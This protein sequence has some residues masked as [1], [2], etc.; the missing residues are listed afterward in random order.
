LINQNRESITSTST[1]I[2]FLFSQ[3]LSLQFFDS[4]GFFTLRLSGDQSV[5]SQ[6]NLGQKLD[7]NSKDPDEQKLQNVVEEMAIAAGTPVPEI[8]VL[9]QEEAINAFAAGFTPSDAAIGVTRG[10]L[11]KLNRDELQ[12]VIAHEFSHVLHGDM[13]INIRLIGTLHGILLIA[14]VGHILM[15]VSA[16]SRYSRR[17]SGQSGLAFVAAGVGLLAIGYIGVFFGKLIKSALSRQREFLADAAA[18]QFT[19][20]PHGI[21]GAL[22]KIGGLAEGSKMDTPKAEEASHMF[23]GNALSQSWFNALATHPPLSERIRRID[24]SFRGT[25]ESHPDQTLE[26][27][28]ADSL[29]SGL[30]SQTQSGRSPSTVST[31]DL[32]DQ[33]GNPSDRHLRYAQG[34]MGSLP[35]EFKMASHEVEGAQA[36]IYGLLM[37]PSPDIRQSQL[38]HL[39]EHSPANVQN[40]LGNLLPMF[41]ELGPET[42]LPIIDLALPALRKLSVDQYRTFTA[43][44]IWLIKADAKFELFEMILA[45]V[46]NHHLTPFFAK[47]RKDKVKFR[48]LAS[49]Q[50]EAHYLLSALAHVGQTEPTQ[51]SQAFETGWRGLSLKVPQVLSSENMDIST[52]SRVLDRLVLAS[53]SLK[54]EILHA[55]ASTAGA[56][57]VL[58][59][60]EAELLRAVGDTLDCPIPPMVMN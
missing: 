49:V 31:H 30:A 13:K 51:V 1:K 32:T 17:R 22:K 23:F 2:F 20:N 10:T 59:L 60:D 24:P 29:A 18:V 11:K 44:L 55:C 46:I 6:L 15:R 54:R 34:F 28:Q 37:D 53:P 3:F 21:A 41:K 50:K 27:S 26:M 58:T 8:Y 40:E 43:N 38:E 57:G 47:G 48:S 35:A 12:G 9:N 33:V 14:M 36:L 5:P 39:K 4:S 52:L 25:F 45:K 56:D 16:G 19:R 42:R 7:G